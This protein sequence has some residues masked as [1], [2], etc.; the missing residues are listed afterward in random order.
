MNA[1]LWIVTVLLAVA[2]VVAG[3]MKLLRSK[4]QLDA[5]MAW[6]EDFSGG[7]IKLIGLL[8]VLGALGLVLPA[9]TGIAPVLVPVAALG[10]AA[11]QVG[12]LVTHVRR[13]EKR[14]LVT[15]VILIA[16]LLFVAW[17]RLGP[18]SF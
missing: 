10:L 8:E 12:A 7:T 6:S 11:I 15:N 16:L 13:G 14:E 4:E 18:Y 2:F 17:G 1:V 5:G 3:L 9:L